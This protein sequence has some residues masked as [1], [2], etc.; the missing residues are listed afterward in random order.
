MDVY[1]QMYWDYQDLKQE[2]LNHIAIAC[3]DEYRWTLRILHATIAI[4]YALLSIV[5]AIVSRSYD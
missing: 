2:G 1:E 5:G 4:T 3:D